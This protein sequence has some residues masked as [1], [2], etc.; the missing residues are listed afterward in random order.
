M[1]LVP[2]G[3]GNMN[4]QTLDQDV[5]NLTKAIRQVESGG[6][7][8]ASGASGEKSL[9]Q[10]TPDTWKAYSSEAGVNIPLEQATR[11]Q[12]NQVAYTKIKQWKDQGYNVGQVASM[13]NAGQGKPNAYAEG[14][15]G[16]N[17]HGVQ[18]DTPGYAQKV[19]EAYQGIKGGNLGGN[20]I[21]PPQPQQFT[22]ATTTGA[23]T[24]QQQLTGKEGGL[25]SDIGTSLQ[26]VGQGL[27]DAYRKTATGEINVGSGFLQGGGAIAGRVGDRDWETP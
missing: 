16:T 27:D 15:T 22:P 1:V 3:T 18:Y 6:D 23:Q 19:A 4:P 13:W 10:F 21:Q 25:I 12:Q 2:F 17:Q 7:I 5:V 8:N 14:H 26:G 9:Y 24:L 11:E 20:Y